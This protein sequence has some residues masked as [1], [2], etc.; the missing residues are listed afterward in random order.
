MLFLSK[1]RPVLVFQPRRLASSAMVRVEP[2]S[3]M[4]GARHFQEIAPGA[5][6]DRGEVIAFVDQMEVPAG[7]SDEVLFVL[8]A[9]PWSAS[10]KV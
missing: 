1:W 6:L 4:I 8:R 5:A 10:T 9:V 2:G 3:P 7:T